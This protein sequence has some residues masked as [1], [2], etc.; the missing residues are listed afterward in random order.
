MPPAVNR[1]A[2][3]LYSHRLVED[4]YRFRLHASPDKSPY[5]YVREIVDGER[6]RQFSLAPLEWVTRAGQSRYEQL[7]QRRP[8]SLGTY[9]TYLRQIGQLRGKPRTQALR[10]WACQAIQLAAASRCGSTPWRGSA[11]EAPPS[12]AIPY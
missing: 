5:L 11:T 9:R 7:H 12:S 8:R 10:E 1:S 4:G 6:L 2:L 3:V